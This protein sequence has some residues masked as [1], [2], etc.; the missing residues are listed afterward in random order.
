MSRTPRDHPDPAEHGAGKALPKSVTRGLI[1]GV[2]FLLI[3]AIVGYAIHVS[4]PTGG[5]AGTS[6]GAVVVTAVRNA[7]GPVIPGLHH[8]HP[9][10]TDQVGD[11]LIA[12][13]NC[14]AC[15]ADPEKR[16]SAKQ[17]PDLA[18]AGTRLDPVF[19]QRF[20][21]D[22]AAAD[23]GTTMPHMLGGRSTAERESIAADITAFLV[24]LGQG[25]FQRGDRGDRGDL[26]AE[27]IS[28]GQDLFHAIGC[29]ACHAPRDSDGREVDA[30]G[31]VTLA[32]V[33]F[34]YGLSSLTAFL[35]QPLDVRA[36][37]RMP[38]MTL[39]RAEA[40]AI[41]AWL[42]STESAP[43][44]TAASEA[45]SVARGRQHFIDLNCSAC[46]TL[47]ELPAAREAR[48]L[49]G[50]DPQRGCLA[51][52]SASTP[53]FRLNDE[54]TRAIRAALA[55]PAGPIGDDA[56][57]AMTLTSFNCIACHTRDDYGG[58]S[59]ARDRFFTTS[60]PL[61]GDEARIPPQL[62]LLGA[63]VR[64]DWL[65]GVLFDAAVVR[66]YMHVRMPQ[67]GEPNLADLPEL[68]ARAD[69]VDPVEFPKLE[70]DAERA[71]RDAG[72]L[73][74]GDKGLNCVSCHSFAGKDSPGYNGIDL[75]ISVDRL[76]GDWFYHFM[77]S[78][79]AHRPGITMPAYWAGGVASR[80]D[81]LGGDANAQIHA[82]WHYL[83]LGQS[84]RIPDGIHAV[85][86]R[87]EVADVARTY[88]GRSRI[89]GY[90][91]IAVGFPQEINY[92]FN[93][94]TGTLSGLWRGDYVTVNWSGQGAGGF[95]PASRATQLAQ[96]VSFL[97]AI[98]ADVPWPLRPVMTE[99]NP[100]D[101]DP[102]YPRNHGYA[103]EGYYFDD[104][105]VPTFMYRSGD[106]KIEDRSAPRVSDN[107]TVLVR[108]LE[109]TAP[110]ERTVWFRALTG[111]I[112]SAAPIFEVPGL[113]LRVPEVRTVLRDLGADGEQELLL[114]IPLPQGRSTVTIHYE[115]LN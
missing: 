25:T 23:P 9:L 20:I 30:D 87:L 27:D 17:A 11:V 84:A 104:A 81:I 41:A 91:G 97:G 59:T 2:I 102:L 1:G 71:H 64:A 69:R 31:A 38:D 57:I 75:L 50:L 19:M 51:D 70:N 62:T 28:D 99:E 29:V 8:D 47:D 65:Q 60:E 21:A 89:A 18:D 115:L 76:K 7:P 107:T 24:D 36:S 114:E 40:A 33:P 101:P 96:D 35:F 110:A 98:E 80:T 55:A 74:V 45:G 100:V 56:R 103:F 78:P 54:Q 63:K 109:F 42:L 49:D 14:L 48:P 90:R 53:D 85:Q 58:V 93:A 44:T 13:L 83:S 73:L 32:H 37:G 22:P 10:S 46:H 43:P 108:T 92:A 88:R 34:K 5:L 3:A 15:H 4:R 6:P 61:L 67:Y 106:V 16:L 113:R 94:K 39:T 86:S 77:R 82:I 95:N 68:V 72:R 12:E 66:P 79:T 111:A 26:G 112:V 52:S 105:F